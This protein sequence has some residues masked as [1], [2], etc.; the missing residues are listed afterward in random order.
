MERDRA[1]G[2]VRVRLDRRRVDDVAAMAQE[3]LDY[4]RSNGRRNRRVGDGDD[5]AYDR[6]GVGAEVVVVDLYE[7]V[8]WHHLAGWQDFEDYSVGDVGGTEVKSTRVRSG[9]L[10]VDADP[11]KAPPTRASSLVLVLADDLFEVVGWA[12]NWEAR[13]PLWWDDRLR[14]PCY[15]LPQSRLHDPAWLPIQKEDG[16]GR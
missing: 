16:H 10:F 1:T 2:R 15:A 14:R 3:R 13:D 11:K 8:G 5:L 7:V 6:D 9:R 12:Y 4:A